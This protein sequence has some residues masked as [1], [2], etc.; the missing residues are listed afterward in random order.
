MGSPSYAAA[1]TIRKLEKISN[2]KL[3]NLNNSSSNLIQLNAIHIHLV[4]LMHQKR[5]PRHAILPFLYP[6]SYT[7]SL[8]I[9]CCI[10][11]EAYSHNCTEMQNHQSIKFDLFTSS[12][13]IY[14]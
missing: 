9:Y 4:G 8:A 1:I 12:S 13:L 5:M 10:K 14:W 7:V 3:G 2:T 6:A 11:L